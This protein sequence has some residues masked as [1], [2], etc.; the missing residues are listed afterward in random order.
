MALS[1]SLPH[2]NLGVQGG[3]RGVPTNFTGTPCFLQMS[4]D[5][6]W[7]LINCVFVPGE[8][9]GHDTIS[10]S[11]GK[12]NVRKLRCNDLDMHFVRWPH[13]PAYV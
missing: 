12:M 2:I 5:F 6:P 1:D 4:R 10:L 7:T 3:P 11:L 8:S 9:L 13:T